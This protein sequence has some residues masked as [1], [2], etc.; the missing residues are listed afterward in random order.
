MA[1]AQVKFLR[2]MG[3]GAWLRK[4]SLKSKHLY[5]FN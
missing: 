5:L 2:T 3:K 1:P 4:D